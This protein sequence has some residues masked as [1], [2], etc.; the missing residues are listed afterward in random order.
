[1]YLFPLILDPKHFVR[2]LKVAS[3]EFFEPL[4]WIICEDDVLSFCLAEVN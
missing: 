4:R 1:M 3:Y 2:L